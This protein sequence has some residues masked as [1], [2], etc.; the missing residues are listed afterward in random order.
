MA[1]HR[2]SKAAGYDPRQVKEHI[3]ETPLNEEMSKSFLEY[4]YSVIYARALPDARDGLKPV[5]RRIIY[6][7]GQMNL[8]PDR[9]YMKSARAVG[10][11]MGKLHPHGDSSIYEAMVRLAQPF[12]MRLPLVDGHGNFGSLDDGPA[13]SRY[14][15]ARLAPA[16]LGMNADIDQD[17]VD[18]SPNYDN[19]LKEPQVLPSAIPNLLVNGASG[20]A[21]G[22]ATNMITHNLGEV[23]AAAKY[24]MAHPDAG[25]DELMR[26]VPGPDLP[27]G[28]II[29][30]RDGIRKAYEHG[31]GAFVTRSVTHLENVTARKKAIVVTELPF[32]VGP[33]RV[34]ERISDGVRNHK[35]EG[36]SS[37]ID[38]TDRHN[39]TRLVIEI[40]TGFDPGK[41]LGKLFKYTPLEDSFTI[42]NV[43]LVH[44]R[45]RTM[46]L[47]ELLEVWVE[48]RRTVIHRRS[49]FRRKKALERLH[50]VEG[51]L[52]A[53]VDIDEVIQ[54]IR[55]SDDA[56][57]AK[58]RLMAVFDLDQ[59]QAQY[60][61]DLRLRRLTKMSR[62][63][64]EGERDDL[65]KQLEELERILDSSAELDRVVIQ[66]MDQAVAQWGTPRRTV[67][68]DQEPS[69]GLSPVQSAASNQQTAQQ[70]PGKAAAGNQSALL[71]SGKAS[72]SGDGGDLHM[73]D[74][75]CT[76]MMSAT[77][78]LARSTSGA[79]DAWRSRPRNQDRGHDDQII[80]IFATTTLATYG[81]VTT[82]GRL[83]TAPVADL[84]MIPA[85]ANPNLSGGIVAD[86]L[87]GGTT[88]TDTQADEHAITVIDMADSRPLALGTRLGTVKRWNRESPTTMDSWSII[89]L[90]RED[91][92]VFAA[93]CQEQDRMVFI[94][95]D[96]SLLTFTGNK[97]RPQGRHAAGM[98]GI[99]LS[100][101]CQVVTFA[102]VPAGEISWTYEETGEDGMSIQAGAV[103]LTVAGDSEAL[104]GTENGA[105]K[106]TPLEMY[107]VKGRGTGGVRSQRFL[108]GQDTLLLARV[109]AWPLHAS[110]AAGSP[111]ELPDVDMR[112][113]ASGQEL[114]APIAF[115]A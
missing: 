25:L 102:V 33:E 62:I 28:G 8:N 24:L 44:G 5:Q 59:T 35:L 15:E 47:K 95:S 110:T 97:V 96:A 2:R 72:L 48:H 73:E 58:T 41:V 34:L 14:T 54:V 4:A 39:G 85:T 19:K 106:L 101:G 29:V 64:L 103:V 22:M 86:E 75:P 12:A 49:E 82:A 115:V 30:G 55:S 107:P 37:A 3:V 105:A 67:I 109:G 7:M 21:V 16:A 27:G 11:V 83:I 13:A 74:K 87:L 51:L 93:P 114:A 99:R 52:L 18:F 61:L 70:T 100:Q 9:P 20:I 91:Q 63:E 69:G 66:E 90:K 38:L 42:N 26:Y 60:I 68:L 53:L 112:R 36:I 77:G 94:S 23:V 78:L 57:A 108:K 89:D 46:G 80:A 88:S 81:L 1:T 65:N 71:A 17:T 43:A 76:V 104:P 98:A 84:P 32:M 45:P 113:D 40:K 56:D 79:L 10:E 92:V 31:R 111:I 50:L 6:Q